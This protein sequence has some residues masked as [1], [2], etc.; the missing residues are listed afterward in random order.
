[1]SELLHA[2]CL[3][4]NHQ[5]QR[6]AAPREAPSSFTHSDESDSLLLC[7][8]NQKGTFVIDIFGFFFDSTLTVQILDCCY[9]R[10]QNSGNHSPISADALPLLF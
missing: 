4:T 2:C 8:N 7:L 10:L 6:A 5:G 1:M 9:F 3:I